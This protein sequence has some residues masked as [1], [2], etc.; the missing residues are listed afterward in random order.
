MLRVMTYNIGFGGGDDDGTNRLPLIQEVVRSAR[1]DVLAVQE[2]NEFE[3]RAQRR[4]FAF[5]AAT[6]LRG[7][8]GLSPGGFHVSLFLRR[9]LQ[10][11]A[12]WTEVPPGN[13]RLELLLRTPRGLELNVCSTHLDAISPDMRLAGAHYLPAAPPAIVMGDFNN[14]RSDDPD[15]AQAFA[16]SAPRRRARAGATQVDDRLFGVLERAGYVDLFRLAAPTRPR[17]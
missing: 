17:I 14:Y 15:A 3:L 12:L 9:D 16:T 6:D 1:P 11:V 4:R 8:L 5:E 13:R 10:P 7:L 2:A